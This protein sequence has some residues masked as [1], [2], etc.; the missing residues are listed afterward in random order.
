[1][2]CLVGRPIGPK[3]VHRYSTAFKTT[4]VKFKAYIRFYNHHG[5]HSGIDYATRRKSMRDWGREAVSTF[6][7]DGHG[8]LRGSQAIEGVM[9]QP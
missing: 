5:L 6:S 1:M 3:K 8:P 7:G 4:A 9:P 2:G